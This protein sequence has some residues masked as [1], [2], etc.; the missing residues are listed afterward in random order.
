MS[1]AFHVQSV[2][3]TPHLQSHPPTSRQPAATMDGFLD[4]PL[5]LVPMI[6]EQ[7]CKDSNFDNRCTHALASVCLTCRLNNFGTKNL[8]HDLEC[9]KTF[10]SLLIRTLIKRPDI[11]QHVRSARVQVQLPVNCP[12][13]VKTYF[14][15]RIENAHPGRETEYMF[16]KRPYQFAAAML[17]S[18]CPNLKTPRGP[19]ASL[20]HV[21][22]LSSQHPDETE[23][24]SILALELQPGRMGTW[25]SSPSDSSSTQYSRNVPLRGVR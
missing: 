12:P 17:A 23:E 21:P 3:A 20:E 6:V 16:K 13:N 4:L 18:L 22:V 11:A 24:G 10:W 2:P 15:E 8:Y 14:Q 5:E 25:A 9:I 19:D 7:L 1:V